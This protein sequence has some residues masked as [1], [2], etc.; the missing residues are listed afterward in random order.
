MRRFARRANPTDNITRRFAFLVG[1]ARRAIRIP[2][3]DDAEAICMNADN[4]YCI[5]AHMV[6]TA[7]YLTPGEFLA[8]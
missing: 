2:F 8:L 1:I 5:S 3:A 7:F 6:T 4:T